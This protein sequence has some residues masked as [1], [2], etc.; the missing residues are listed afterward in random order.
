MKKSIIIGLIVLLSLLMVAGLAEADPGP[1]PGVA[2]AAKMDGGA[3]GWVYL[4]AYYSGSY[5]YLYSNGARGHATVKCKAELVSGAPVYAV[6]E[7]PAPNYSF[8]CF[9]GE[10][11][12]TYFEFN[13]D[14]LIV[15]AQC[16]G[17][18]AP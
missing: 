13:G 17:L 9:P 6:L 2:P 15:V 12:S 3:C 11:R 4:G 8:L 1:P 16:F 5:E 14:K 18:W 10:I 7:F